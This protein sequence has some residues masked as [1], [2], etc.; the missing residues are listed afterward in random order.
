MAEETKEI[1][2][3]EQPVV[4]EEVKET[5]PE[6]LVSRVSKVR[7]EKPVVEEKFNVNE[8]EKIKDPDARAYIEK[9]YKSLQGDYT[10]KYQAL[11]EERKGLEAK[12]V[13]ETGWTS[14]RVQSLLNDPEFI[15]AAQGVVGSQQTDEYSAL[16]E[17]EKRRLENAEN[18][19]K[20]ILQQNAQLL[21]QQQYERLSQKYANFEPQVLDSISA[22]V[23]AKKRQISYEDVWKAVDYEEAVQRA[24]RLGKEDKQLE[25][26]DK[27]NSMSAEGTTVVGDDSPPPQENGESNLNYFRRLAN[28]RLA[29]KSESVQVRK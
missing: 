6:N 14:E 12:M 24:Y 26:K 29:Q 16:S 22:E 20:S 21:K 15:K 27:I 5:P 7:I 13:S 8:I 28:R 17:T 1:K 3:E 23:L 4:K 25:N 11:S 2:K 9:A 19:A 18:T 10:R